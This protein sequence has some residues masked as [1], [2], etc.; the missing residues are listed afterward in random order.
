M[1]AATGLGGGLTGALEQPASSKA[2]AIGIVMIFM[3]AEQRS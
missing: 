1:T 2:A 3:A